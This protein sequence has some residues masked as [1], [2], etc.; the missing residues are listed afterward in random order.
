M[1]H[2]ESS[3]G[4]IDPLLR[5][6]SIYKCRCY[7]TLHNVRGYCSP[8]MIYSYASRMMWHIGKTASAVS[9]RDVEDMYM[10]LIADKVYVR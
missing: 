1:W 3:P 4:N 6:F 5:T 10:M 8:C 7:R 9:V 2:F